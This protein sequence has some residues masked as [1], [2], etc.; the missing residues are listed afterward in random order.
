[1][2]FTKREI[3]GN[4]LINTLKNK[5][6]SC[7][8][9]IV[10]TKTQN[11]VTFFENKNCYITMYCHVSQ[12]SFYCQFFETIHKATNHRPQTNCLQNSQNIFVY[13]FC[14]TFL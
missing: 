10:P 4:R 9:L 5:R 7:H 12:V 2:D 14:L 1:M 6:Y 8:N 11:I 3:V 13:H